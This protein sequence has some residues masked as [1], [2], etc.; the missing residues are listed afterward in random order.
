MSGV[1]P[2][3]ILASLS[4]MLSP[5][6]A[7]AQHIA[8]SQVA[9]GLVLVPFQFRDTSGEP[10]DQTADHE[11]RLADAMQTAVSELAGT[12]LVVPSLLEC[13]DCAPGLVELMDK[14]RG[15][16]ARYLLLGYF[17]KMS[18]LVGWVKFA[19]FDLEVNDPRCDRF[20]T[21]RGDTDEA[22]F[23]AS[24]MMVR[25]IARNCLPHSSEN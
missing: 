17:H 21:Y 14:A 15:Q 16:G 6:L 8:P 1:R 23:R 11:R 13:D 22:W 4:L 18:T 3:A 25:D 20:L 7:G 5:I 2:I 24:R 9:P 19:V 12:A 10:R